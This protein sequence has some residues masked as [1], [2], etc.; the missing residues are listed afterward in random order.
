MR[1]VLVA[2]LLSLALCPAAPDASVPSLG[3]LCAEWL[4]LLVACAA[5][6]ARMERALWLAAAT[7]ALA[8]WALDP[9]AWVVAAALLLI[10]AVNRTVAPDSR[11]KAPVLLALGAGAAL[12][13]AATL[14]IAILAESDGG[15]VTEVL[16]PL[17]AA[18]AE[19]FAPLGLVL[20]AWVAATLAHG[21]RGELRVPRAL[22]W[23]VAIGALAVAVARGR[24]FAS[25]ATFPAEM[26][27]SEAPHLTNLLKLEAGVPLYGSFEDCNSYVYSPLLE[28]VHRA[29]LRP[30][31]LALDLMAHRGRRSLARHHDGALGVGALAAAARDRRGARRW[32]F[33]AA[34]RRH[35][36][37]RGAER[38]SRPPA[39]DRLRRGD[40]LGRG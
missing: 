9:R 39:D 38:S 2:F 40:R 6:N 8:L 16:R 17:R 22:P 21:A 3:L 30:F 25:V 11:P 13:L 32:G 37:F 5:T 27:W 33:A 23:L 10:A 26:R 19:P 34:D 36:Q 4:C 35:V 29:L 15:L 28:F 20:A 31:G 7:A 1:Y 18:R 14:A 12:P 24:W